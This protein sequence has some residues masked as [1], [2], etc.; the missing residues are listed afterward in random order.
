ML[1][2]LV[3]AIEV[4]CSQERAFDTFVGGMGNW[5]PLDKRAMSKMDGDKP[6][7]LTIEPELGGRIV[8]ISE[9]GKEHHWGTITQFDRPGKVVMDF[10]MGMPPEQTSVVE[11]VFSPNGENSTQVVLTQSNWEGFGDM[12]EMIR[13][14]Y[15]ESWPMLFAEC[16]KAGCSS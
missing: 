5:W 13:D 16:Y 12:A 9:G 7:C 1:E 2:P 4:A 6:K 15:V 3:Y 14:G 8:E 11:V 10:H